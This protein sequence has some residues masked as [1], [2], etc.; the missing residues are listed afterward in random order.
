M[1]SCYTR[2]QEEHV[3]SLHL[4]RSNVFP[5]TGRASENLQQ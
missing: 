3:Y 4:I 1:K 5:Q 2:A